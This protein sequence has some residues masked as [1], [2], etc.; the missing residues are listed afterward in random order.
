MK[1]MTLVNLVPK[2]G[3]ETAV[4]IGPL[5]VATVLEQAGCE[6]DFRDYQSAPYEN[7][8]TQKNII[9]FLSD[10][11]DILGVSCLL[12]TLPFLLPSLKKLKAEIP[13]KTI[14]LGG[15]GA[16][17]A[18]EKLLERFPFIDLVVKGEGEHTAVDLA[19]GLPY[20]DIRGIVFHSNGKVVSTPERERIHHLD[21]VPFPAYDKVDL[22]RY[23]QVG[24]I[25]ARGC[26]YHCTFCEVAP[27]WGYH[28]EQ[29]S[30]SNVIAE[31]KTLHDTYGVKLLHIYDDT[32]VLN[33]KWVLNFC[34]ALKAEKMDI[35]WRCMGRINLMDEEL[36]SHMA[37]AG[38][39]SIQYGIESGSERILKRVGKQITVPQAE[40]VV[41]LSVEYIERVVTTFMWGFPFETMGDFF[42][43]IFL[44]GK[45]SG[46]GSLV[47]LLLLHPAPSSSLYREYAD[48][49][50]FK[51]E[52]ATTLLWGPFKDRALSEEKKEVFEMIIQNPD[53]FSGFHYVYSP[54]VEKK[55][56]FLK[57]AG[58]L[59]EVK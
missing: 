58:L 55:H 18:A 14:I 2:L 8:L 16:T 46:M 33:R 11:E 7:P 24:V 10:S 49:L 23:D 27:L 37:D 53:I 54:D 1:S 12:S 51:E 57:K 32:F 40:K 5:Y 17:C 45:L 39:V 4:P 42:K 56:Q 22:L 38:C 13:E 48:Q 36:L 50:Q 35:T 44:M 26:T 41:K 19:K 29:R 52:F 34:E 6:V 20:H 25:T 28:N 3:S 15:P 21:E 31:I 30:V 43:T 47:R 9:E 59:R